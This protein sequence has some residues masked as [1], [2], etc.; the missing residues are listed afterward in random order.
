ML[1]ET[2]PRHKV[3]RVFDLK[4]HRPGV[5]GV[6]YQAVDTRVLG[7][8]P[9]A[10]F[11]DLLFDFRSHQ[12]LARMNREQ[13]PHMSTLFSISALYPCVLAVSAR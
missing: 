9:Y 6:G 3:P 8:Q 2:R 12:E 7:R 11:G 5:S 4:R 10:G 1:I 13:R